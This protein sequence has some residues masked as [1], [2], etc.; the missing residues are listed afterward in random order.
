MRITYLLQII[1]YDG[2][3]ES[4]ELHSCSSIVYEYW[5]DIHS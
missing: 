3:D 2:V 5:S 4:S 1:C